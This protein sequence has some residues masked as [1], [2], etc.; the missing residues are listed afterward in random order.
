MGL[1]LVK[2]EERLLFDASAAAVVAQAVVDG[3][4][5]G[6][7]AENHDVA[8]EAAEMEPVNLESQ[9]EE[10]APSVLLISSE[11]EGADQLAA[12]AAAGVIVV[13]YNAETD[14]LAD[15]FQK[16]SDALDGQ[17]AATIGFATHGQSGLF[18]LTQEIYVSESSLDSNDGLQQFW[19]DVGSVVQEGG[20]V[21]LL[22]CN[23][24]NEG[25]GLLNHL[26]VLL[27]DADIAAS[28]DMTGNHI[29]A[30]WV[31][32]S[33]NVDAS[34]YL[35]T[36][37]WQGS[38]ATFTVTNTLNAG[39][40]SLRQA[41]LDA[42]LTVAV[43]TIEFS[44]AMLGVNPTI[45]LTTALP[46]L[47]Q[48]VIIDGSTG[49][50]FGTDMVT[51]DGSGIAG[52]P[53]GF[54]FAT[55]N[56]T[57]SEIHGLVIRGF[58]GAILTNAAANEITIRDNVII[59][60]ENP[61]PGGGIG[62]VL[63]SDRNEVYDNYIGVD[64]DGDTIVA[65]EHGIFMTFGATDNDIYDNVISG[66][67]VAGITGTS[68]FN[69]PS[70]TANRIYDNT[71]GLNAAGDTARANGV[72]I[73][74]SV[75]ANDHEI[76]DNVISGNTGSGVVVNG[77]TGTI[78]T[79]NT[80]G[81]NV[82]GDTVIGNGIHGID[83]VNADSNTVGG[84]GVGDMNVIS[85]NVSQ[86]IH[87]SG[88]SLNV[89]QGNYIG[90]D[91]TGALD[92]GNGANGVLLESSSNTNRVEDNVISGNT[93]SGVEVDGSTANTL[94]GNLIGL[95]AAGTAALGNSLHGV[96][97][98]SAD[99][100]TIGGLLV[101]DR[102]VISGNF[103]HG[104]LFTG[105]STNTLQGNYIGTDSTGMVDLG[106]R[107]HGLDLS[108][109]SQTN[110]ID[111]NV[112]SGNDRHGI[113]I[114]QNS[115]ANEM[116]RN[117]IGL[118]ADESGALGNSRFGITINQNS[119][120]GNIVGDQSD[121]TMGNVISGN[122]W[123][124]IRL[125]Q[126]DFNEIYGN[127][128]GTNS[129]ATMTFA[130]GDGGIRLQNG[131]NDSIIGLFD[132]G[133]TVKGV[134]NTISGNAGPGI[135]IDGGSRTRIG[136]NYIGT[137]AAVAAGFGN[138]D[139]GILISGTSADNTIGGDRVDGLG[140]F[141]MS[142]T[143][144]GVG[145]RVTSTAGAQTIQGNFVGALGV[146][147][148]GD[149]IVLENTATNTVGGTTTPGGIELGNVVSANGGRGIV[150]T[151]GSP[152]LQGNFVGTDSFASAVFGNAGTGIYISS[153]LSVTVGGAGDLRNI[154]SGNGGEGIH[155]DGS[156][157]AMI[158]NNLIGT[159][160]TGLLDFGNAANGIKVDGGAT[161]PTISD[162]TIFGNGGHGVLLD[163]VSSI[164]LTMN[165]IT[166]N[167]MDGVKVLT[168]AVPTLTGNT[169]TENSGN[170][171][172]LDGVSDAMITSNGVTKNLMDGVN[173]KSSTNPTLTSNTINENSGNGVAFDTV[174]GGMLTTNT[175]ESNL[176]SGVRFVS[177]DSNTIDTDTVG[178]NSMNGI[179]LTDSSMNTIKSSLVSEN[180]SNGV[181]LDGTSQDN[182]I[183][184]NNTIAMNG[185]SGVL[186]D[187]VD[188]FG[189]TISKNSIFDNGDLGITLANGANDGIIPPSLAFAKFEG[190]EL[191]IDGKFAGILNDA[192]EIQFFANLT[193]DPSGRGEGRIYFGSS[194]A[195]G[196][197]PDTGFV[198]VLNAPLPSGSTLV[199]AT[200]TNLNTGD[201]SEFS[202]T[203]EVLNAIFTPPIDTGSLPVETGESNLP[204]DANQGLQNTYFNGSSLDFN[205]PFWG[206]Q[207]TDA[208]YAMQFTIESGEVI[209][210][211]RD[212]AVGVKQ[213]V[214]ALDEANQ[215]GE[216]GNTD[217]EVYLVMDAFYM[218]GADELED[219]ASG[220]FERLQN[221][222]EAFM[223][224]LE[225]K[226]R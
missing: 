83:F 93:L 88:S 69:L 48:E 116:S 134:A 138:T 76:Y 124:G 147:N 26:D 195:L 118:N 114:R 98:V 180:S 112:I 82:A 133:G 90:T 198:F 107:L 153:P 128:I 215:T 129:A 74:L 183:G 113:R 155:I 199:S 7:A 11:V 87:F 190:S 169:V 21:D 220:F 68:I 189:N 43:D 100:N 62:I 71:I 117:I 27:G 136:G 105:S 35:A 31:L 152:I 89:V 111:S 187:G 45:S 225:Q 214:V 172:S 18:H 130:N 17:M 20:R 208:R 213:L 226:A 163:S 174:T 176:M 22:G 12:S 186:V 182:L 115:D 77:T 5:E 170:G 142:T 156:P 16:I 179:Y 205:S 41:I 78:F 149:G 29:E 79:G 1:R 9:S 135:Q 197:G 150:V 146:G 33:G 96:S 141:I 61:Q 181:A 196:A 103:R 99:S 188:A 80:I 36:A 40:G 32:E 218:I 209:F 30:N 154:V 200:L 81:L 52:L 168:S 131:A 13:E 70:P 221:F 46:V 132:D 123:W 55:A 219:E 109:S 224:W 47:T 85:G 161:S 14:S 56:T 126:S 201:T 4:G 206:K 164:M 95:N 65:N 6:D 120:N 139:Y 207:F 25:D 144:L 38:L 106:N 67:I 222:F 75:S 39:V 151:D 158:T 194:F 165:T 177:S 184:E 148:A 143:G 166:K 60:N 92:R 49:W 175:I 15:I 210:V 193:T 94:T 171:I 173:V 101:G 66:N 104:V 42:N 58:N 8:P 211:K 185:A 10:Q 53:L 202:F 159:D 19:R 24:A 102:N 203:V 3:Q 63:L 59:D 34:F 223:Q 192:Y 212:Q 57:G 121:P 119:T 157:S 91:I 167:M 51:V 28:S 54:N 217:P 50:T 73:S 122:G 97:F 108:G 127:S 191:Q 110:T 140:N 204:G 125:N 44:A 137:T 64:M 86:G 216:I 2:L 72:G 37:E 23:I 145:I 162:N 178:K 160:L 84:L